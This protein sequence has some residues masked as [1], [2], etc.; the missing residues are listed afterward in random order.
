M[1]GKWGDKL[2]QHGVGAKSCSNDEN[3]DLR[4][5]LGAHF[6][7]CEDKELWKFSGTLGAYGGAECS[8]ESLKPSQMGIQQ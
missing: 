1:G 4:D 2:V 5:L 6:W 7:R 3:I 8:L